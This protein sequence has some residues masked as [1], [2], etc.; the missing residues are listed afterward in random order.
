MKLF[1]FLTLG[2]VMSLNFE[3]LSYT[4]LKGAFSKVKLT[5]LSLPQNGQLM[6]RLIYR[7]L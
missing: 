6:S 2:G 1:Q 7:V 3:D 4:K 5:F